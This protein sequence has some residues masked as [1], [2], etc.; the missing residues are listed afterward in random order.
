MSR[1]KAAKRGSLTRP[2]RFGATSFCPLSASWLRVL[3]TRHAFSACRAGYQDRPRPRENCGS[4][5]QPRLRGLPWKKWCRSGRPGS[6]FISSSTTSPLIKRNCFA[7]SSNSIRMCS[8]TSRPPILA[9]STKSNCGSPKSSAK[10][11]PVA[12][13]PRPPIWLANSA[14][15]STPTRPTLATGNTLTSSRRLRTNEFSAAVH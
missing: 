9:G 7:I 6:R 15:T 3:P 4:P 8:F 2:R 10:S 14:A 1:S 12:S 5:H 13:S 11:W